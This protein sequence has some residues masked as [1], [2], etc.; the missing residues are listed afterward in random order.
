[1]SWK[2][3]HAWRSHEERFEERAPA[4]SWIWAAG[5]G[6]QTVAAEHLPSYLQEFP[7]VH[8]GIVLKML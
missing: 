2:T 8:V 1:M 7:K 6:W 4:T 5:F 3:P